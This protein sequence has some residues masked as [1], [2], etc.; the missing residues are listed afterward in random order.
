L[1]E[2]LIAMRLLLV[3][4]DAMVGARLRRGLRRDGFDVDWLRD[5]RGAQAALQWRS[6]SLVVIDLELPRAERVAI[7]QALH[8]SG[9]SAPVVIINPRGGGKHFLV[10]ASAFDELVFRVRTAAYRHAGPE[11]SEDATIALPFSWG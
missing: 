3:E 6:Y 5:A 4:D 9:R 7:L 2:G 8:Q 10:A 1:A 11:R